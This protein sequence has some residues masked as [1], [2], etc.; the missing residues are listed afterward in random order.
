M[1]A[2][3]LR[4]L[5][6]KEA[7]EVLRISEGALRQRLLRGQVRTVHLGASVRIPEAYLAEALGLR[8]PEAT[9]V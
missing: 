1:N 6:V 5:T 9:P 2:N 7:A 4:L 3:V 8:E